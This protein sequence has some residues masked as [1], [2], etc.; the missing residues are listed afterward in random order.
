MK[1]LTRR[2]MMATTT[3]ALAAAVFAPGAALANTTIPD[4]K[5]GM[6]QIVFYRGGSTAGNAVRFTIE[7]ANG[8]TVANLHRGSVDVVD[9][10]PGDNFF[11]VPEANNTEGTITV[12]AGQT[13]FI[14]CY[15][16]AATFAGKLQFEEVSRERAYK[17]LRIK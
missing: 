15:L 10:P 6:G 9:V 3:A 11:R 7:D 4:P 5:P 2:Q 14:R 8:K 1:T 16:N 13:L 12:K 17:E